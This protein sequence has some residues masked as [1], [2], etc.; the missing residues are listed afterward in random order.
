M[1][2][3]VSIQST[4]FI[5]RFIG[6]EFSNDKSINEMNRWMNKATDE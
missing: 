1:D 3:K 4:M 5:L 2:E 6:V